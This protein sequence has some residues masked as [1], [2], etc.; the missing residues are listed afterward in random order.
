ME[1][2]ARPKSGNALRAWAAAILRGAPVA[3]A[4]TDG[5]AKA[6][7]PPPP[8]PPAASSLTPTWPVNEDFELKM[9]GSVFSECPVP[10]QY[11]G[12]PLM[13]LGRL[14]DGTLGIDL[15]LHD[16]SG[17]LLARVR[18]NRL[19]GR[20]AARFVTARTED[21]WALIERGSGAKL[22]EFRRLDAGR[23]EAAFKLRAPDGS[24]WEATPDQMDLRPMIVK[25]GDFR[26]CKVG[27]SIGRR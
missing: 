9:G 21:R 8:A 15:D 18:G 10:I 12:W 5:T 24:L 11:A 19:I 26:K 1:G 7:E 14:P 6:V 2:R 17:E 20:D 22:C 4:G 13:T 16:A 25:Q 23:L 27:I 3:S